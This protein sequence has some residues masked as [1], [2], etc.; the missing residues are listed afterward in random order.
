MAGGTDTATDLPF[1]GR[2]RDDKDQ[3]GDEE[4][5]P[6]EPEPNKD[7]IYNNEEEDNNLQTKID[8]TPNDNPQP[9]WTLS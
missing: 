1:E 2:Y 5:E 3:E 9:D 7:L 8:D 6:E 4:Y